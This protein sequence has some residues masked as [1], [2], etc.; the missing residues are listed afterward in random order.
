[1][2][3]L[4]LHPPKIPPKIPEHVSGGEFLSSK[5]GWVGLEFLASKLGWVG[6]EL[7]LGKL[8]WMGFGRWCLT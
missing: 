4:H 7:P 6:L 2:H 8:E 1:M 3:F 5:L